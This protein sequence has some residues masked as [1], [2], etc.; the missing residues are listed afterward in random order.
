MY[1]GGDA[2]H[3]HRMYSDAQFRIT[4]LEREIEGYKMGADAEAERSDEEYKLR[5][6]AERERDE[7]RDKWMECA[8]EANEWRSDAARREA[9]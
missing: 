4:E 5:L 8:G 2:E 1:E 3:W 6:E 7:Y 9:R